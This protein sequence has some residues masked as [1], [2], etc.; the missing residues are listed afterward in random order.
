MK[1]RY[2]GK[3]NARLKKLLADAVLDKEAVVLVADF[4]ISGHYVT[5]ILDQVVRFR[6]YPKADTADQGPE[7][8][9]GD[10]TQLCGLS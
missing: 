9:G 2:M 6:G 3:E 4:G 10:I 8:N 7:F 5:R 1:K